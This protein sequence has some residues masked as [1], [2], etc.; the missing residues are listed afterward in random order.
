M[1]QLQ[2]AV[3][4]PICEVQRADSRDYSRMGEWVRPWANGLPVRR[5]GGKIAAMRIESWN[6]ELGG[7]RWWARALSFAGLVGVLL[8]VVGPFGS[9]FNAGILM[10]VL[11][12]AGTILGGTVIAGVLVPLSMR[13]GNAI[14][15]PKLFTLGVT[16]IVVSAP[17]GAMSW[18]VGHKLWPWQIAGVGPVEWYGQTVMTVAGIFAL[19]ALIEVARES[20]RGPAIETAA[21]AVP[22]PR[23]AG[24]D[25]VLCLQMEDHYVRVHRLSGSKLELLPLQEA[26]ARF[27]GADG[28]QVHRS[29]WVAGAAIAGAERDARNWRL[30]LTNGLAVPVAR[31]RVAE[32]RTLG[33]I[34][35]E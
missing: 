33:W 32:A 2:N 9:F 21:P 28:L 31:N 25:P 30:R 8:G 13:L 16:T 18:V 12:W 14:G 15:L 1:M 20:V 27:G 29:W 26:I 4:H 22:A 34:A 23:S 35:G 10:R 17:I 7:P 19:W 11:Y 24:P 5:A 6:G 3:F